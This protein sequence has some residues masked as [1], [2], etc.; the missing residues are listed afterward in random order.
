ML[1]FLVKTSN[2]ISYNNNNNKLQQA[3]KLACEN[4]SQQELIYSNFEKFKDFKIIIELEKFGS[5]KLTV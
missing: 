5:L 1:L 2:K 4:E 3:S